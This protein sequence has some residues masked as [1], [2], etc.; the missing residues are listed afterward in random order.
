MNI[1]SLLDLRSGLFT[2]GPQG[3]RLPGAI[4]EVTD[5]DEFVFEPD[6]PLSVTVGSI[7]KVSDGQDSIL[8]KVIDRTDRGIRLCIECYSS[9]GHERRQEFRIYDKIYYS[10]DLLGH[11]SEMVEV[12][13]AAVERIRANKLIIDSFLKGRYGYPG[14]DT[15]PYANETHFNQSIW[16]INRK[17][18]LLIHMVLAEEFRDLMKT[19]PKDV[20]IS[21]S[22]IRFI[23]EK[24][25]EKGDVLEIHLILPMVPLLFISLVGEVTRQKTVTSSR[26]QRY[27]VAAQ[28]V[29]VDAETKDDIIR[30]LFRRQREVLRKK[31]A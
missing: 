31:Q 14:S 19:S 11:A 2:I 17:L 23:S 3:Q 21:A 22:G 10:A 18:D 6:A 7:V 26:T 13:P 9:P 28:F 20:N 24:S 8:A 15:E 27:A 5:E 16:E 25:F 1:D 29:R 30:Y 4:S 12:L